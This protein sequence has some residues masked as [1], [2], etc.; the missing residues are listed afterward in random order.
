MLFSIV[1]A[2][3]SWAV[4]AKEKPFDPAFFSLY[5]LSLCAAH[6]AHYLTSK[7]NYE[8]TTTPIQPN[9]EKKE[10]LT[11]GV[12]AAINPIDFLAVQALSNLDHYS[13]ASPDKPSH[14]GLTC[15][16][17]LLTLT[18]GRVTF[19]LLVMLCLLAMPKQ[20]ASSPAFN[21]PCSFKSDI[22]SDINGNGLNANILDFNSVCSP[23]D[24]AWKGFSPSE[25][26]FNCAVT[27]KS[28]NWEFLCKN[29]IQSVNI[30][31]LSSYAETSQ[32]DPIS[33]PLSSS[34]LTQAKDPHEFMEILTSLSESQVVPDS[35]EKLSALHKTLSSLQNILFKS[36]TF[37]SA[38]LK[39]N[40]K[41]QQDYLS[42][43]NQ[44]V[45]S[46]HP[47]ERMAIKKLSY[48]TNKLLFPLFLTA[49]KNRIP[50]R[51][52][53]FGKDNRPDNVFGF[54]AVYVVGQFGF[55]QNGAISALS[56]IEDYS[57]LPYQGPHTRFK[58]ELK[59]VYTFVKTLLHEGSHASQLSCEQ[60]AN[61]LSIAKLM[62]NSANTIQY[63]KNQG[64]LSEDVWPF[65][66]NYH[67]NSLETAAEYQ[68]YFHLNGH[69]DFL[70]PY[71]FN[72]HNDAII[73][74]YSG[75]PDIQ[76]TLYEF[77]DAYTKFLTLLEQHYPPATQLDFK[78]ISAITNEF[79]GPPPSTL[80]QFSNFML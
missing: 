68:T 14:K 52:G 79:I 38:F 59:N 23:T 1:Y 61:I 57:A 10:L 41:D 19:K 46:E 70:S 71:D 49:F 55:S 22:N 63:Y 17:T 21:S 33:F 80:E 50:L 35:Q 75:N 62:H 47:T 67:T 45:F 25:D 26:S 60:D 78:K 6:T 43:W 72:R 31:C 48:E 8:D 2:S 12:K 76:Q 51:V 7:S 56:W 64:K 18:S 66:T 40:T 36:Q 9:Q 16:D 24:A 20:P 32:Q 65:L 27:F 37:R 53:V 28:A 15:L 69:Y 77:Q 44:R 29:D 74:Q 13:K 30:S 54:S 3:A 73:D 5:L 42:R 4:H 11:F 58:G 39:L 34:A